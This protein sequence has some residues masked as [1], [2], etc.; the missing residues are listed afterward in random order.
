MSQYANGLQELMATLQRTKESGAASFT[1]ARLMV[2]DHFLLGMSQPLRRTLQESLKLG[3]NL[4]MHKVLEEAITL[5]KD[6]QLK[7]TPAVPQAVVATVRESNIE[8]RMT[9]LEEVVRE[10]KETLTVR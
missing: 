4:T 5:E 9:F 10:L 3:P 7:S 8:L 6:E 1:N 2:Q